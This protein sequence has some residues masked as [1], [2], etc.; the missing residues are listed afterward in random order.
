M[1][2][3]TL[4]LAAMR[5]VRAAVAAGGEQHRRPR[6]LV[7]CAWRGAI[8]TVLALAMVL[9]ASA[10]AFI[11]FQ[12]QASASSGIPGAGSR[13]LY[14]V[15][16]DGKNPQL[17][18]AGYVGGLSVAPDGESLVYIASN[19]SG[20]KLGL[21]R[22]AL[23]GSPPEQLSTEAIRDVRHT[24]D[25][26]RLYAL[27]AS[28]WVEMNLDASDPQPV[29]ISGTNLAVSSTGDLATTR[30]N[31]SHV[32]VTNSSGQESR[33]IS[34]P[35]N[36]TS[37]SSP[38]FSPD[39]RYIAYVGN[40][41]QGGSIIFV[42][43]VL[44]GEELGRVNWTVNSL[45]WD[46][47]PGRGASGFVVDQNFLS[48]IGMSGAQQVLNFNF[49]SMKYLRFPQ[50]GTLEPEEPPLSEAD[51]QSF[52]PLLMFDSGEP[53]RPLEIESFLGEGNHA[54][55]EGNNGTC[56]TL[57]GSA[58]LR[59]FPSAD[60]FINV[61]GDAG[62]P[63]DYTTPNLECLT[64][65]LRD[66]DS[67]PRSAI[68][69]HQ[70]CCGGAGYSYLDYWW[71]YR[72]NDAPTGEF[73]HEGDWEGVSIARSFN[74]QTFDFAS[75]AQHEHRYNYLR[76]TL[77]CDAGG[78]LSCG[79]RD[80]QAGKRLHVFPANGTHASYAK[81][82]DNIGWCE[83]VG[84]LP[85]S[86]HDGEA[87]WGRNNDP[88][89]LIPFAIPRGW[90]Y[91]ELANWVDWPGKWGLV[92]GGPGGPSSPGLQDRFLRP[93]QSDC[94]EVYVDGSCPQEGFPTAYAG[95]ASSSARDSLTEKRRRFAGDS[96]CGT[97]FGAA[98]AVATCDVSRLR[99]ALARTALTPQR[100]VLVRVHRRSRTL[101]D[102]T[103]R[104]GASASGVTQNLGR[105]L[106]PGDRVVV[107]AVHRTHR[108]AL[109]RS[110]VK[111]R[112]VSTRLSLRLASGQRK[113]LVVG[114]RG[115][116]RPLPTTAP[117][118]RSTRTA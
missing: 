19:S 2:G 45:I 35:A 46:E 62:T 15:D 102:S 39:G 87:P 91:P 88:A 81:P 66:C 26:Q 22:L 83:Q 8:P 111:G 65:T 68:Y 56:T 34:D 67:G 11:V 14:R 75:F 24:P 42:H 17:L 48:R 101:T 77:Q 50:T 79:T 98:I 103:N 54:V 92:T 25:G 70:V 86:D 114:P 16:N 36:V 80:N 33:R 96:R 4:G 27:K 107:R 93:W 9:P 84:G 108:I 20:S 117:D 53:W 73:D 61:A 28:G 85:E 5:L 6:R 69:Y 99:R 43:D 38:A 60:A 100:S 3:R 49:G 116:V 10:D 59:S 18:R 64:S 1:A 112:E 110:L 55:C 72:Y 47:D 94:A 89:A 58:D 115:R 78:A 113:T 57:T 51:A 37:A 30:G 13:G 44:T 23:D 40:R 109:V 21:Y 32:Y 95:R 105:P 31:P 76:E 29:A 74:R 118:H 71:Y 106:Q 7:A 52:R 104:P 97:W 90:R 82:C 41:T 12:G 63:S